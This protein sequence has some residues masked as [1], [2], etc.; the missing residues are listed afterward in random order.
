M[1]WIKI[2]D[3]F[4]VQQNSSVYNENGDHRTVFYAE[5]GLVMHFI[6]DNQW[7]PQAGKYFNLTVNDHVPVDDAIQQAFGMSAPQLDKALHAYLSSGRYKYYP[8]PT[9]AGIASSGYTSKPL[10]PLDTKSALADMHLHSTDYQEKAIAEFEEVLKAQP[11]NAAALRGLGYA[12]LIKQD[13]Q[14][15]GDRFNKAVEHDSD[16]PRVLY[17]SALLIQREGGLTSAN[18]VAGLAVIEKR[19]QKSVAL[20]PDFADAYSLL[21]FT[22]MSEGK[23]DEA[24]QTM[25][26]AVK[27]N[28][29][30]DGYVFNLGQMCLMNRKYDDAI[31]LFAQ[32]QKSSNEQIA[33]QSQ[34]A[35]STA[36]EA[37]HAEASGRRVEVLPASREPEGKLVADKTVPPLPPS[38]EPPANIPTSTLRFNEREIAQ[39]RL[40]QRSIGVIDGCLRK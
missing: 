31:S 26:K 7:M 19:L 2:A 33:A 12:Y 38:P 18:P 39:H 27:L 29:R 11:E 20:D 28:P 23:H 35:L 16:D 3:L 5:S 25:I 30:N 37:K 8:I 15:A 40:F 22:Y 1:G 17:Y 13:F 32:L 21:A 9:P 6:Y 14:R 4:R 36:L 34:Q 24:I 10:S